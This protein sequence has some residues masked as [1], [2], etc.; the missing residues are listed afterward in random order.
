MRRNEVLDILR[1]HCAE[2]QAMGVKSL[3]VFGSVAR[4]E[5]T[6]DSDIDLLVEFSKPVGLFA[7]LRVQHYLEDLFGGVKVDLVMPDALYEELREEIFKEAIRA[8]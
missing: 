1:T 6:T 2:L 8:A 3:A 7:F 5:A 4:D